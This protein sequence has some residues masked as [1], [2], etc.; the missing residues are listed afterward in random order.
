LIVPQ[1]WIRAIREYCGT[2]SCTIDPLQADGLK[3]AALSGTS[4]FGS[5]S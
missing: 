3:F 2:D 1:L 4:C 5:H